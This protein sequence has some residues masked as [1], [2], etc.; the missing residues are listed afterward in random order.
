LSQFQY[1]A[2]S[3][4]GEDKEGIIDAPTIDL[5]VS[6]L[7]KKNFL[8][9]E[10]VPI[11]EDEQFN[12]ASW[13]SWFGRIKQSEIVIL[14]RQLSTLF[15]AKVPVVDSLKILA[16][17]SQ[18]QILRRHLIDVLD[19]IQGGLSMS[20]SMSK[21]PAVFSPFYVTMVKSGEESG[22]L[23]EIFTFLA[24]YL[25]RNYDLTRKAKHALTYPAF[26]FLAF[27]G[28]MVLMMV[29]VIPRLSEIL[30]ESGQTLPIYT[31]LVIGTSEFLQNFGIIVLVF[32][33]VLVFVLMKYARTDAGKDY[34][35]KLIISAPIFGNIF[36]KLYLSR[37]ADN[38]N[39]L[40]SG[41]V[42]VLRSLEITSEVV[43]NEAYRKILLDASES[44]RGGSTIADSFS[45]YEDIPPLFS[46]MLRI[47]EETGKL[48]FILHSIARF[49]RRD[50][51]Y[52]INNLVSLIEPI[53]I[54]TL[55]LGVGVLVAAVLLP[56]YNL[57]GAF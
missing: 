10:I 37:V 36:K 50:V 40:L 47:G 1:K 20:V 22:K 46:Q 42:S 55:G 30:I 57:A 2:K 13:S 31:R 26:V 44:V 27:I 45:R 23:E 39:T 52:L 38:L 28:V 5:A 7:Q 56:I 41:G 14:S 54:L 29:V 53:L 3:S 32:I 16:S 15:E 18:N 48:G 35:A 33:G 43:G 4:D 51:D 17:E 49:Y 25:E 8:I 19:D 21:H 6:S 9:T 12:L 11:I 34:F 24:D